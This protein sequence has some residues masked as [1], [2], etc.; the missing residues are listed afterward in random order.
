M[1]VRFR[2][3]PVEGSAW[4]RAGLVG[5]RRLVGGAW[6]KAAG[7][8]GSEHVERAR[9]ASTWSEQ[10][11]L[12]R[13]TA[14]RRALPSDTDYADAGQ[15]FADREGKRGEFRALQEFQRRVLRADNGNIIATGGEGYAS[16]ATAQAGIESV[17]K[18]APGATV[19]EV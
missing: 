3:S 16:K 6:W 19:E 8:P 5:P 13:D 4:L 7:R 9:G 1:H 12:A 15:R 17:K 14:R 10:I 18:N 11:Y 2:S